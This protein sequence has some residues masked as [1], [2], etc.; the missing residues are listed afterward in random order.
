MQTKK[1]TIL[2][3]SIVT[4]AAALQF[5][6][7]ID[8]AALFAI[9]RIELTAQSMENVELYDR[10]ED[11]FSLS[12]LYSS[13]KAD[14]Q[15]IKDNLF[16]AMHMA[17][18]RADFMDMDSYGMD[19]ALNK[20]E[21]ANLL[22]I[23]SPHPMS[24]E[25]S[26]YI[27]DWV[28]KGGNAVFLSYTPN[29]DLYQMLGIAANRGYFLEPVEGFNIVDYIFPGLDDIYLEDVLQASLDVDLMN[30]SRVLAEA[31]GGIPLVWKNRFGQ[32]EILY[33]NTTVVQAKSFR[34]FLLA[35]ISHLPEYF[36]STILNSVVFHI[37][38]FP[39]PIKLGT[40]PAV[41]DYYRLS[42]PE[43]FK[44]IWWPATYNFALRHNLKLTG[45]AIITFNEDTVSP[46]A[47]IN[48]L[49]HEQILYFGRR[50]SEI[51]G[52]LGIHGYNHQ[53]LALEGQMLF[54][55]YGY[56]PWESVETMEEGLSI[57]KTTIRD[58]FGEANVFTYVPPSNIISKEGRIA[59]KNVF[60]DV[61]VF[62]GLY[63]GGQ[64][65][66]LLLQEFG[67]DPYVPDAV[68]F[69]RNS[70]G[71]LYHEPL[72][73]NIFNLIANYGVVS[74]FIHPDDIFDERRSGGLS[75]EEMDRQIDMMF[76]RIRNYFPF[77][78][79]MTTV[80]AYKH[81]I[82]KESIEVFTSRK[83]SEI[84][85]EYNQSRKL[86]IY[87]YLK[88]K[89]ERVASVDGGK[90]KIISRSHDLYLIESTSDRV[91]ITVR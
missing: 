61:K 12:V 31:D 16:Y 86:P 91:T 66:G 34:G 55:E 46:L 72:M 73:W 21:A 52:E 38:D 75:W 20:I 57:L 30:N 35:C 7:I 64:E 41:Y 6:R 39:A 84:I 47:Q 25:V 68:S 81:F 36:V 45:L 88:L 9:N 67:R 58:T 14:S 28:E 51:G 29:E 4:I 85:I 63:I 65:P 50:L 62:A 17:K 26:G 18:I 60:E 3:L 5:L 13:T 90:F 79:G 49:E 40:H 8:V 53:S 56:T 77:L 32:G 27:A 22:V 19:N 43:I 80:E 2:I 1:L 24:D 69:P 33:V 70:S 82:D 76:A 37:D 83:G 23:A 59:V 10:P 74:H 44:Q 42:T 87:H 89:G 71:Y 11:Y 15:I 48:E 54:E 78:R